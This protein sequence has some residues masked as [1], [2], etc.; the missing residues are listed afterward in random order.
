[1]QNLKRVFRIN[2]SEVPRDHD[3]FLGPTHFGP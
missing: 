1:L 3:R 2:V